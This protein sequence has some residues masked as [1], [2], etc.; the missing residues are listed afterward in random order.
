MSEPM[1][2]THVSAPVLALLDAACTALAVDEVA[3]D[4]MFL[5]CKD[6]QCEWFV[7]T[8]DGQ[9]HVWAAGRAEPEV[10][11]WL[12][13]SERV[14]RFASAIGAELLSL[15]LVDDVTVVASD[16]VVSAAIDQVPYDR[17][18]PASYDVQTVARASLPMSV[19]SVLLDAARALPAGVD[20]S[21]GLMPPMW[22]HLGGGTLGLHIDWQD[23]L[24]NRATYRADVADQVGEATVAIP[25]LRVDLFLRGLAAMEWDG[26]SEV[27][28]EVG[29]VRQHDGERGVLTLQAGWWRLLLWLTDPLDERWGA[30]VDEVF[31]AAEGLRVIDRDGVEW[32]VADA[33]HEVRVKLHAGHP[34]VARVSVPLVQRATV[35]FEL[36]H[37]LSQLNASSD[38]VRFWAADDA[39]FAA[40]DVACSELGSLPRAVRRVIDAKH[41]YGPLLAMF[42]EHGVDAGTLP[43]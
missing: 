26:N 5:H 15:S 36:L 1:L 3:G 33:V 9:L 25:H 24:P 21:S 31:G 34:D 8:G 4:A 14:R 42:G 40:V 43:L 20:G 28:I 18:E 6:Q 16:G 41:R 29:R 13:V 38:G 22:L 12:A 17:P 19:L 39:V 7:E 11:G 2:L 37:E 23:H 30:A 10:V 32:I 27:V 35:S